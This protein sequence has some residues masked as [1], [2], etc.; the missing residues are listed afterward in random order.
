MRHKFTFFIGLIAS[1]VFGASL[2][3]PIFAEEDNTQDSIEPIECTGNE[4]HSY[5]SNEYRCTTDGAG[6]ETCEY[7][8]TSNT[9]SSEDV[10][11]EASLELIAEDPEM[12]PVYL[13]LGAIGVTFLLIVIINLTSRK[14]N[15]K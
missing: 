7:I 5:C 2:A 4:Y 8:T 10:T 3:T 1:V 11:E 14:Y 12:W 9:E 13:S 15:R 6:V